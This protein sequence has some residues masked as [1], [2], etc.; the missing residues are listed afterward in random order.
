MSKVAQLRSYRVQEG[1]LLQFVQEW[2]Q[3]VVPLRRRLGFRVEGAWTMEEESRFV[4]IISLEGTRAD[5]EERDAAYYGSEERKSL[6]PDPARLLEQT[7][8][9]LMAPVELGDA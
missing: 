8:H 5:F 3:G 7:E 6:Q 9:H 2:R 1:S 4:W